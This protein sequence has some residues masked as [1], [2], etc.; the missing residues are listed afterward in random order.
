MK[1][2]SLAAPPAGCVVESPKAPVLQTQRWRREDR[3][4]SS[5]V[6]KDETVVALDRLQAC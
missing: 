2:L 6:T 3:S 4:F 5:A 1:S